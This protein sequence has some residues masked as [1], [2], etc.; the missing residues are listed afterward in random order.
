MP[1]LI[2]FLLTHTLLLA[3][4]IPFNAVALDTVTL[5]LKWTHSFEY[6]GYYAALEQ[7]YYRDAGLTV[8]IKEA[9][10]GFDAVTEVTD[11]KAEYGIGS[12]SLILDHKAGKPVVVIAVI[13]Q[14]S[15]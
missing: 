15:P 11:G 4:S 7:G 6:A 14:H 5:Q 13:L 10:P 3:S 9:Q 1:Q 2:R 12:S 8:G